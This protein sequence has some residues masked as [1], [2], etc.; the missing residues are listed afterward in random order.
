MI[1]MIATALLLAILIGH[2]MGQTFWLTLIARGA[3]FAIAAVGLSFIVGQGGLVSFGHAAPFGV[4]AYA[5]LIAG[6][7]G[8]TDIFI[9]LP[10]AFLS[11]AVFAILTGLVALRARGVY[12]IMSTLA[13]AQMAYFVFSSLSVLGGDDGAPLAMRSTFLGK[14]ILKSELGLA[15]FSVLIMW[16]V[17]VSLDRIS[18]S[19][20]GVV[21][22][23]L[24]DNEGRLAALGFSAFPYHLTAYAIAAGIAGIA[25]TLLANHS[26]FVAPAY[27][28]WHRSG[29]F[30]V[31]VVLGGVARLNGALLGAI[32]VILMEEALGHFTEYWKIA[33]GLMLVA[34]VL[35]RGS[36]LR[37][38]KWGPTRA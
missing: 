26:E 34:I 27:M 35:V 10:V 7:L 13:L 2:V 11:G 17:A 36:P 16:V 5:A 19:R 28:N 12:F 23:G 1:H 38:P 33:L 3:I 4:G 20:F 31:M 15:L 22:R 14:Q 9:V 21:L 37:W 24:K 30:I 18:R 8:A 6:E 25:G 29:E 32:G